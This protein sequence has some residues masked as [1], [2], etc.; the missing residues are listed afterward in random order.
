[1]FDGLFLDSFF[2][3]L[4]GPSREKLIS[5]KL[6][7]YRS[8]GPQAFVFVFLSERQYKLQIQRS[9][10]MPVLL[11]PTAGCDEP[12]A[13]SQGAVRTGCTEKECSLGSASHS[14]ACLIKDT[15]SQ[16]PCRAEQVQRQS[17]VSTESRLITL[18]IHTGEPGVR[19]NNGSG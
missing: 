1:M 10:M 14:N 5:S 17:S 13:V 3:Q 19:P 15:A 4:S 8:D 11:K 18:Q 2:N 12:H 7:T 9:D 6:T 16:H